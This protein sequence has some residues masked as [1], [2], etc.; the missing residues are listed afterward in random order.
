[1]NV[2]FYL[3]PFLG[4]CDLPFVAQLRAKCINVKYL[5]EAHPCSNFNHIK[6]IVE[7]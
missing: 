1:M 6:Y 7:N 2:L 4:D 5:S 3:K